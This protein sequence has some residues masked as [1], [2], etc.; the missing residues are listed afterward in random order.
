MKSYNTPA[1]AKNLREIEAMASM[2]VARSNKVSNGTV[3]SVPPVD[4]K[5]EEEAGTEA[6][7]EAPT[8]K[9]RSKKASKEI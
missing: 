2:P 7:T 9:A 4:E 6:Q 3:Q 1:Q 8:K 5:E